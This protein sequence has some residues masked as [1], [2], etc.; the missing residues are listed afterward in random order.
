M[1]KMGARVV[2]TPRDIEP[3]EFTHSLLPLPKMQPARR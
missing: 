1:T 3:V 2:V